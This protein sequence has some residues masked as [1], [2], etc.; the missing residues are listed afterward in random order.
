VPYSLC[1][2]ENLY[3]YIYSRKPQQT[4]L[5]PSTCAAELTILR[6]I[7]PEDGQYWSKHVAYVDGTNKICCGLRLYMFIRRFHKI[8]ESYS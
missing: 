4:I 8:A 1:E 6:H 7:M 2:I 3:I 5:V